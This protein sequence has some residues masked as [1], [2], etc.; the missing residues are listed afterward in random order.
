MAK[1]D[2][3]TLVVRLEAQMRSYEREMAKTRQTTDRQLR[4]V[5][6]RYQKAGKAIEAS[7]AKTAAVATRNLE[8]ALVGA[9]TG[10]AGAATGALAGFFAMFTGAKFI[11]A[12]VEQERVEKQLEQTIRS[13]GGAA[14][15]TADE[16]KKLAAT[17]QQVTKF[18]DETIIM[19]EAQLL[20]FTNIGRDVFPEALEAALDMSTVLGTDLKSNILQVGKALNDPV[21]GVS[22]LREVGVSF[23]AQQQQQIKTLVESGR[24]AEAMRMIL[25]ELRVEFGNSARAARQTLGGALESLNNA[26]GD[27][28]E[29]PTSQTEE[30]R[31]ELERLIAVLQDPAFAGAIQT[32]GAGI[33]EE[34][35]GVLK[36]ITDL[37]KA[38]I[39]IRD[40]LKAGDPAAAVRVLG[41]LDLSTL[42][43]LANP[44][45]GLTDKLFGR[46]AKA[47][48][49]RL[50]EITQELIDLEKQL[51]EAR[52]AAASPIDASLGIS[53]A[54]VQQLEGRVATLRKEE[55]QVRAALAAKPPSI[56][57]TVKKPPAKPQASSASSETKREFDPFTR[58][59]SQ[60]QRSI[61]VIDAETATIGLNTEA[62]DRAR[63]VALLEEAAKRTNTEAGLKS[64]EVTETQR[65]KIEE[66]ATAMEQ[67]ARRERVLSEA[68][69]RID[70]AA[71]GAAD[72]FAGWVT[73]SQTAGEAFTRFANSVIQDILRMQAKAMIMSIIAPNGAGSGAVSALASLFGSGGFGVGMASGGQVRGSGTGTSDSVPAMLSKGEYVVNAAAT[74]GNLPLLEALNSGRLAG[75]ADGGVVMPPGIA[76]VARASRAPAVNVVV[77][78]APGVT[79]KT[80]VGT[81]GTVI[82][83]M[84]Y[85]AVQTRMASDL[86]RGRGA[87]A[88]AAKRR[89]TLRG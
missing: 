68:F 79:A 54:K 38:A 80:S 85:D 32:I 87:M 30:F 21:A 33:I 25:A 14:G 18:G 70:S 16:L 13:T 55:E 27:L 61:A 51:A 41:G 26:L 60:A 10:L 72:A 31:Q 20:T 34:F 39:G 83:D 15:Y 67:A 46:D 78:E 6:Q 45:M 88:K 35:R 66:V 12:T 37:Y 53:R 69:D 43:Q 44:A 4:A 58:A 29:V 48:A 19:A 28:F 84:I 1:T 49:T 11:T 75:F 65:Q 9:A 81:D 74:A 50:S 24:V 52:V 8:G 89:T 59:V 62:R 40:A 63:T 5:E 73:E 17:M 7:T 86:S 23:T 36:Q 77:N 71:D 42:K 57:I 47:D 56:A 2:L 76:P 22:A 64:T 82:V 3:E